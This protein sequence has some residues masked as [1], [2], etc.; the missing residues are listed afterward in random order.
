MEFIYVKDYDELSIMTA[1]KMLD[2][3]KKKKNLNLCLAS[4]GSP[5]KAYQL[6]VDK[7][8][9]NNIDVSELVI[10]KLDEWV[11]VSKD[12]ELSCEKYLNDLILSPLNIKK[13]HFIT[14]EPDCNAVQV[15]VERVKEQLET[16]KI[17]LC[18]LGFGINGHLGLNE[19][20]EF[21]HPY[22]HQAHLDERTKKHPM[23]QGN[24]LAYGMTIGMKDILNADEVILMMNGKQKEELYK[25]F[26]TG[27]ISTKL[28]ASF[29][30]LHKNVSVIIREDEFSK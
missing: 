6:F 4:G 15:E 24:D 22:A 18:I 28:P 23:L 14:F 27:K 25:E 19:P 16:N 10:T 5:K 30:W 8:K 21:L 17:N 2:T 1:N 20:G 3:L 7:V 12:S 26:L 11:G 13:D 9:E 29:L